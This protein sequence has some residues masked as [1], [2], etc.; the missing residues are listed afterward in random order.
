MIKHNSH[1][2]DWTSLTLGCT[3]TCSGYNRSQTTPLKQ[4]TIHFISSQ[5]MY[6]KKPQ[7]FSLK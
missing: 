1:K 7:Y 3:V 6:E 5:Q 2:A 4:K